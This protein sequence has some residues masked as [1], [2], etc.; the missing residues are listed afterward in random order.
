M[1]ADADTKPAAKRPRKL[2]REP[3]SKEANKATP[4]QESKT[5][6]GLLPVWRTLR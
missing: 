4:K 1:I 5:N 3:K 2:A 6:L